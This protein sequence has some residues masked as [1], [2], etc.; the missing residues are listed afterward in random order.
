MAF[1]AMPQTVT[2]DTHL[3]FP[4]VAETHRAL[5]DPFFFFS[6]ETESHCV[7]QAGV[8]WRGLTATSASWIHGTIGT[9][10]HTQL[11]FCIFIRGG[12]S[13]CWPGWS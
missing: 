8:Q 5:S 3:P 9:C 12:V 6:F 11:I 1:P 2:S 4:A 10:H 13:L 7:T